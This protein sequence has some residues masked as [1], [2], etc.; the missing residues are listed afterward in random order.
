MVTVH[1]KTINGALENERVEQIMRYAYARHPYSNR[2]PVA[3][4]QFKKSKI[5]LFELALKKGRLQIINE[6]HVD[7]LI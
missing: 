2:R 4:Q 5:A 3:V 6:M 7:L 1:I